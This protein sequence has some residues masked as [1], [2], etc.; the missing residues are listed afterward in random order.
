MDFLRDLGRRLAHVT[1]E[2]KSMMYLPPPEALC[3]ST[4]RE[5]YFFAGD[6]GSFSHLRHFR[7]FLVVVIVVFVVLFFVFCWLLHCIVLCIVLC[8]CIMYYV[9]YYVLYYVFV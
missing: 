4:K 2:A 6:N 9:L 7:F 8:I 1:G 3:G 5:C